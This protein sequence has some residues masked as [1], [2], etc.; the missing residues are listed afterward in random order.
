MGWAA[1]TQNTGAAAGKAGLCEC[2][3]KDLCSACLP[4]ACVLLVKYR[5]YRAVVG[6]VGGL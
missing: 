3:G 1:A 2:S 4:A 6:M 5:G